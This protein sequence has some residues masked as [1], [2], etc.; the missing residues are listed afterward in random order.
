MCKE[1]FNHDY[2]YKQIRIRSKKNDSVRITGSLFGEIYTLNMRVVKPACQIQANIA[3]RMD[4]LQVYHE[5]FGHQHKRHVKE[6]LERFNI[7]I[8]E[9]EK[10]FCDGCAIGKTH[11]LPFR[12]KPLQSKVVG[13][14]IHADVN[15]P[16]RINSL[17]KLKY[18]VCFKDNYSKFRRIFFLSNKN[19]VFKAFEQFLNK[20]ETNGHIVK[21]L[22]YDGGKKFDNKDV[23]ELLRNRGIK[24]LIPPPYTLQLNGS[25]ERENRTIV[26]AARSILNSVN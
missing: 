10:T 21:K 1:W 3:T 26:E 13:E 6:I 19:E 4:M 20:A 22:R 8:A 16:I 25:A 11:R 23:A 18:Y 14:L 15:G 7:N 5:R 9:V 24:Q 2:G 12:N 17:G